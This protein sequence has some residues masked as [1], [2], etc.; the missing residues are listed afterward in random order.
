MKFRV[1]AAAGSMAAV[2]LALATT[3]PAVAHAAS[4]PQQTLRLTAGAESAPGVWT[5]LRMDVGPHTSGK[6]YLG[7]FGSN[8]VLDAD[9]QRYDAKTKKWST[10]P[11]DSYGST[12]VATSTSSKAASISLRFR[13][14]ALDFW[15]VKPG[16]SVKATVT[17]AHFAG[18]RDINDAS[19]TT[20]VRSVT[21]KLTGVKNSSTKRGVLHPF[22]LTTSNT[23]KR[24]L[25]AVGQGM[26]IVGA[27]KAKSATAKDFQLQQWETDSQGHGS[28]KNLTLVDKNGVHATGISPAGKALAPGKTATYK[29]RLAV[30]TTALS[31]LNE[32]GVRVTTVQGSQAIATTVGDYW[33]QLDWD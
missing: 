10:I 26:W 4:V 24:S 33:G 29:F 11:S 19:D 20:L 6:A 21:T 28:W 22:T 17:A 30:R 7:L 9:F 2:T 32:V 5:S 18:G 27:H 3:A 25:S 14:A 13:P 8:G 12:S 1:I 15:T 23:T 31:G 16:G